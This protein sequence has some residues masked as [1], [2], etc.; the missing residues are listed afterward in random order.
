MRN[1]RELIYFSLKSICRDFL[2]INFRVR[3]ECFQVSLI[4]VQLAVTDAVHLGVGGGIVERIK[5]ALEGSAGFFLS[6]KLSSLCPS[7]LLLCSAPYY[8]LTYSF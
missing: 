7:N 5:E 8:A 1:T 2:E 3:E 6:G 4:G